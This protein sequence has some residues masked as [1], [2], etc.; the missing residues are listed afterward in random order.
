MFLIRLL[1]YLLY[2]LCFPYKVFEEIVLHFF[3]FSYF[4]ETTIMTNS[5]E[6]SYVP[7]KYWPAPSCCHFSSR[8]DALQEACAAPPGTESVRMITIRIT[9]IGAQWY[10]KAQ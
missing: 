4:S 2:F 9:D 3:F 6:M 8:H 7:G 1:S 10:Y 5:D